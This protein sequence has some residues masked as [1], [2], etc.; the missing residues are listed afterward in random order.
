MLPNNIGRARRFL[1]KGVFSVYRELTLIGL[2]FQS[3]AVAQWFQH[4]NFRPVS[5]NGR[6]STLLPPIFRKLPPLIFLQLLLT[7]GTCLSP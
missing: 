6:S 7:A 4:G 5:L 1:P 2:D 3:A